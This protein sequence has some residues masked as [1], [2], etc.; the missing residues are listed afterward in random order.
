MD[1]SRRF[2]VA[3]T[4]LV[5]LPGLPWFDPHRIAARLFGEM[6]PDYPLAIAL[7]GLTGVILAFAFAAVV[8]ES[9]VKDKSLGYLID[10]IG[11]ERKDG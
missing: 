3:A 7:L 1:L 2:I 10:T 6:T 8:V 9:R 11:D 5:I 4:V